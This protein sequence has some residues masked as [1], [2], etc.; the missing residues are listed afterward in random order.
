MFTAAHYLR[1]SLPLAGLFLPVVLEEPWSASA[2]TAIRMLFC[3]GSMLFISAAWSE[4]KEIVSGWLVLIEALAALA[5]GILLV[6]LING[7][8]TMFRSSGKDNLVFVLMPA[9]WL[10]WGYTAGVPRWQFLLVLYLAWINFWALQLIAQAR[11]GALLM[12]EEAKE[13]VPAT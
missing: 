1:L 8:M 4:K 9:C 10:I 7:F 11:L 3:L 13:Q 12:E 2:L 5:K 6:L